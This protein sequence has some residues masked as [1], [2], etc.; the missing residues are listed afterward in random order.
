MFLKKSLPESLY[1]F[2]DL[3]GAFVCTEAKILNICQHPF[4]LD[5]SGFPFLMAKQNL[6]VSIPPP[7]V[8]VQEDGGK[9]ITKA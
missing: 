7:P 3:A 6:D 8:A 4:F 5:L 2:I 1:L 9:L